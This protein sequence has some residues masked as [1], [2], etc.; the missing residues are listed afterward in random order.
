MNCWTQ[1]LESMAQPPIRAVPRLTTQS[2]AVGASEQT[3]RA[4][5]TSSQLTN[6]AHLKISNSRSFAPTGHGIVG[7]HTRVTPGEL[8]KFVTVSHK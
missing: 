4:A 8:I 1:Y 3:T 7:A 2:L 6:Q 5:Y